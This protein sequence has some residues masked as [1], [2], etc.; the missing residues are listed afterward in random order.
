MPPPSL[1]TSCMASQ[2]G[3]LVRLDKLHRQ[4]TS[5]LSAS[6][7]ATTSKAL[8]CYVHLLLCAST[9]RQQAR[10]LVSPFGSHL[11][12]LL[13]LLASDATAACLCCYCR[14]PQAAPRRTSLQQ[15]R[16]PTHTTSFPAC[17]RGEYFQPLCGGYGSCCC[18]SCCGAC[19][20]CSSA[21]ASNLGPC[22]NFDD[23]AGR[24]MT[25]QIGEE[26]GGSIL[27]GSMISLNLG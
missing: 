3:D 21:P 9:A 7:A 1:R 25:M 15:P 13:P 4:I 19:C 27:A 22:S 5:F 20:A 24:A 23:K 17:P 2:V 14:C 6:H 8:I 11:A 18:C 10:S 16:Q 12:V 26:T